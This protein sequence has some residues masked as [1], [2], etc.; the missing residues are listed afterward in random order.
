MR[1][2]VGFRAAAPPPD[3]PRRGAIVSSPRLASARPPQAMNAMF[4]LLF[5]FCPRSNAGAPVDAARPSPLRRRRTHAASSAAAASSCS[6]SSCS[7]PTGRNTVPAIVANQ[8]PSSSRPHPMA[9][10]HGSGP[11]PHAFFLSMAGFITRERFPRK[12]QAG[13]VGGYRI[14]RCRDRAGHEHS[15]DSLRSSYVLQRT[16]KTWAHSL[17][18]RW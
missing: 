17:G 1:C 8:W 5:R 9:H 12:R 16:L 18:R 11:E 10:F 7:T 6:P 13:D 14:R 2:S 4:S 15:M 3:A